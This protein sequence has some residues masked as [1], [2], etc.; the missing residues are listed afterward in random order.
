[1]LARYVAPAVLHLRKKIA[2]PGWIAAAFVLISF[3]EISQV[4][5]GVVFAKLQSDAAVYLVQAKHLW[6]NGTAWNFPLG[7][8]LPPIVYSPIPA[9]LRASLFGLTD[10]AAVLVRLIQ[11]QNVAVLL[12][13][14][15]VS[16]HYLRLRLAPEL[17]GWSYTPFA[18]IPI[19]YNPWVLNTLLPLGDHL[20]ALMT[21]GAMV[22]LLRSEQTAPVAPTSVSQRLL[23]IA[24]TAIATFQKFTGISL[25]AFTARLWFKRT[26]AWRW[27]AAAAVVEGF[28][29]VAG[30]T[31]FGVY[32]HTGVTHYFSGR[33][34]LSILID[35]VTNLVVAAIPNQILPNFSYLVSRDF[36]ASH[37]VTADSLTTHNMPWIVI[38]AALTSIVLHGAYRERLRLQPEILLLLVCVP[39]Y[40]AATNSTSRYLCSVQPVFWTLF[41]SGARP[42]W[43]TLQARRRLLMPVG[44][45]V[46]LI[47]SALVMANI[48]RSFTAAPHAEPAILP[49]FMRS[50]G[51]SFQ[52]AQHQL[53]LMSRQD[54]DA[55]FVLLDDEIRWYALADVR[56]ISPAVAHEHLCRGMSVFTVFACDA[57][58]CP[59]L[60]RGYKAATQQ[61]LGP[62]IAFETVYREATRAAN[63]TVSRLRL[64]DARACSTD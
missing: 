10:N 26:H 31:L 47:Y 32:V 38:G 29:L 42:L 9:V 21:M 35:S 34:S 56:Y 59:R 24:L 39:V 50:L 5:P 23:G 4:S 55:T 48:S 51:E 37:A 13:L 43:H 57:R 18:Y 7:E 49:G 14:A 62:D 44:G 19:T 28:V 25:L 46:A 17:Q 52:S 36:T 41:L 30:R 58:N 20:Y 6:T 45:V 54:P 2:V 3:L 63:I 8:G 61:S 22:A 27:I 64:R 53:L 60:D 11:L 1:M 33:S 15:L 40:A 16:R 12:L